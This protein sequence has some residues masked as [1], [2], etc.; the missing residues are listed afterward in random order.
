VSGSQGTSFELASGTYAAGS[1][2]VRQVDLVGNTSG[3]AQLDEITVDT[4]APDAPSL[5]LAADTG[6]SDA[7]GIT[8]I[9]TVNVGDLEANASWEYSTDA[10]VS[11]LTGIGISFDLASG[12]YGAGSILVRQLDLAGNTSGTAQLDEIIVDTNAPDAP[13]LALAADTG[14]SDADGI[15]NNGT[16]NVFGLE[17]GASWEFSIDAGTSWLAGTG[18]SFE[19]ASGSY[20]AG[21][22]LVR[23]VDL[24]GNTS[25]T[26]QLDEITVDISAPDAP[27]LA[28]AADTGAS[29]ADGITN[30]GTVNVFGLEAG[31]SWEY[32]TD[33]GTSWLAGTGAL[34]H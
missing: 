15:T 19:L 25:D 5:Y 7:D 28:L 23:Q 2:L 3:T 34:H 4:S 6:A 22:I 18:S 24:A 12:T 10:G 21:S 16:V 31:A 29:D 33:A 32:S 30:N 14:A 11:W 13:S 26:A 1:I 8:Y 20:G 9:G 27:S 17:D